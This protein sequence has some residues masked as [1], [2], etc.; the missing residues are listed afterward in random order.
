[1]TGKYPQGERISLERQN[2]K[3]AGVPNQIMMMV[4]KAFMYT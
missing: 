4:F 1:M 3:Q 2:D